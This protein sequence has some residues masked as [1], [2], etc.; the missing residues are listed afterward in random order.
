MGL[1]DRFFTRP[2]TTS[3]LPAQ[4]VDTSLV[5]G[6]DPDGLYQYENFNIE[7]GSPLFKKDYE[8]IL[9]DKQGNIQKLFSLAN[10]Y[11]DADPIVHGIIYHVYVPYTLSSPYQLIGNEKTVKIYEAYYD[12]IRIEEALTNIAVELHTYNNVFVYIR[13]GIPTTLPVNRCK[14][15][16]F[17]KN[18]EPLVQF[19]CQAI[20]NDF[21]HDGYTVKENWIQTDDLW[22]LVEAY[23]PEVQQALNDCTPWVQLNPKYCKVL[24]GP[25]E[26]WTRYAVPFISAALGALQTKELIGKYEKALLNLGIHSFVL[27]K[28]GGDMKDKTVL[29][30]AADITRM[31]KMFKQGMTGFPLVSANHL[32]TAEVVQPDMDDLFQ[33][34]KFRVVNNDIL[35]AGGISGV[36]VNG[37]SNDGST[38]ASAQVSMQTAEARILHARKLICELM[39]KVNIC[40]K[41]RLQREF[42][43]NLKEV[44]EFT[45]MP[46][47]MTGQKAMRDAATSLYM[48]GLLSNETYMRT[49]G[50]DMQQE[51]ARRKAEAEKGI[52]EVLMNRQQ[53]I[54][55][56]R[57]DE[58]SSAGRP[59]LTVEE[60][61]S[62]PAAAE[63]SKQP[64]PS[65]PEGS[66]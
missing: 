40:I 4:P 26:M 58:E 17:K 52:D 15:Q 25:R 10:Y 7:Y 64:K 2:S 50:Y 45:F 13:D 14:I 9:L 3:L 30:N 36:L 66:L 62:D 38:F 42:H 23:P 55:Q 56:Q 33:W 37:V 39:N 16:Q 54:A 1:F 5:M 24:Q 32:V 12:K 27:T 43:Y 60:R 51:V 19:D 20:L 59:E 11:R 46:L 31:K 18:G 63:R 49:N 61:V 21:I 8:R 44:P 47:D 22:T 41:E 34:D 29:A 65:N 57:D 6:E 28:Y 48:N 53:Q 35:S